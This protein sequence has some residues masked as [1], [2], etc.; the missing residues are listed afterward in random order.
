MA[1]AL[2]ADLTVLVH[3]GFVAF[4][5]VGGF[6]T[7]RHPGALKAHV[8]AIM[9]ALGI[10]TVGWSCPLTVLEKQLRLW[11]GAG[12]Y[13]GAFLDRYVTGVLYPERYAYVAQALVAAAVLASYAGLWQRRRRAP[14]NS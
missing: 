1:Y 10:V 8:P 12:G 13:P 7:W 9:W 11:A 2:L 4:V 3:L 14:T 6:L 5:A